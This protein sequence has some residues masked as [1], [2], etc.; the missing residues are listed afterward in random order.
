MARIHRTVPTPQSKASKDYSAFRPHVRKDFEE[1]CA[2]C[3]RHE[4]WADGQETFE[5]DH[6]HPLSLF[7]D[8]VCDFYNLYYSCHRCNYLKLDHWPPD[9][10]IQ[11]GIGFVDLCKDNFDQHFRATADGRWEPLTESARYT[12][13]ILRLNGPHLI[14][15]RLHLIQH[16][17][18]LDKP[19]PDKL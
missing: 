16:G 8:K 13:R 14:Q 10:L 18:A 17:Y 7:P 15:R 3:L 9:E 6:F 4:D 2:Y 11:K 1:C 12:A 5:L 19:N